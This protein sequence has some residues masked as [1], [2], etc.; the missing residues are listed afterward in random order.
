MEQKLQEFIH[1]V[2]NGFPTQ[3][4]CRSNISDIRRFAQMAHYAYENNLSFHPDMFKQALMSIE[5][6]KDLSTD[7]IASKSTCLCRQADFAKLILHAEYD[8]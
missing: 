5:K 8:F 3:D 4:V 2:C 6:F 7:E 1:T